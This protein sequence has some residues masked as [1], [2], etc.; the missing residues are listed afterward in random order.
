MP[1]SH[2]DI[3][4]KYESLKSGIRAIEQKIQSLTY[5][6]EALEADLMEL[7][8]YVDSLN[9]LE[10]LDPELSNFFG[11]NKITQIWL[12]V[13]IKLNH[14]K[15]TALSF[16]EAA[17]RQN[18]LNDP[19]GLILAQIEEARFNDKIQEALDT[20]GLASWF[21]MGT[22][23]YDYNS[24]CRRLPP[25]NDKVASSFP[26]ASLPW[27]GRLDET[28]GILFSFFSELLN[29]PKLNITTEDKQRAEANIQRAEANT[30]ML[31]M[32]E[33]IFL[34]LQSNQLA[35]ADIFSKLQSFQQLASELG[36]QRWILQ[37]LEPLFKHHYLLTKDFSAEFIGYIREMSLNVSEKEI[38]RFIQ[39][40]LNRR[41]TEI[42]CA[43]SFYS[44]QSRGQTTAGAAQETDNLGT[45]LADMS[46]TRKGNT[47]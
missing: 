39:I 31:E 21:L 20:S 40:T 16:I 46:Q 36:L 19:D 26:R 34:P 6:D 11:K 3:A 28:H 12:C 8:H 35:E 1:A 2:I 38:P 32:T 33:H 10:S 4:D 17:I 25:D 23:G 7:N 15:K 14:L 13:L 44:S 18:Q 22:I 37:N 27:R 24:L 30:V 29:N 41:S 9:H 45:Q 47:F 42:D 43:S 5:T